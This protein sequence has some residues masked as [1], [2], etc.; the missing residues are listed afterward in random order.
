MKTIDHASTSSSLL[1]TSKSDRHERSINVCR[2]GLNIDGKAYQVPC[3]IEVPFKA[4]PKPVLT[5]GTSN[6]HI[7]E[8]PATSAPVKR[9]DSL[10]DDKRSSKRRRL[11]SEEIELLDEPIDD[12]VILE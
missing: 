11:D 5:N 8:E 4:S 6:G 12:D 7:V 1:F 2:S 10:T 9:L 3:G